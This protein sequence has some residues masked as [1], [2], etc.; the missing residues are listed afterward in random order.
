MDAVRYAVRQ[1]LAARVFTTAAV[2]TLALGI[3]GTTAIFTLI[4]AVMLKSL[5]VA[6]P[7]RLYRIGDGT[8]CCVEGGPQDEWGLFSYPLFKK[9]REAAPEFD[10]VTAFQAGSGRL[11]VRRAGTDAAAKPLIAEYVT[12][13]YFTTLGVGAFGGRMLT[14]ADDAAGAPPVVVLSHHVWQTAYGSDA[15]LVG[16]SLVIEGHPFTVIGVS[17]PGFFGETLKGNPP[18]VW[19]P[20]EQEPMIA[21]GN[22]L[23]RQTGGAWLRAIG[24]LRPGASIDG[25]APRLTGLLRNWMQHDAGY[26]ANWMPDIVRQLPKQ[27]IAVVPAGGGI[28]IMKEQY[29]S[30]LQILLAVCG[31][32]LLIACANVANLMLARAVARRTQTAVRLAIG[33]SRATLVLQALVESVVLALGGAA[34]GLL[35]AIGASRLLLTLA[36]SNAQ[37]LPISTAPSLPV[38]G[39]ATALA[40][41][42]GLIFGA[43]PAWFQTRTDPIDALRGAGRVRD[44]SSLARKTLLVIQATL[45]VVLVTGATLLSRTLNNLEIAGVRV[46]GERAGRGVNEPAAGPIRVAEAGRSVS[47]DGRPIGAD[48]RRRRR[49]PRPL[50]P[51]DEQLGR[52][53]PRPGPSAPQARR[54]DRCV[55]GSGQRHLHAELRHEDDPRARVRHVGP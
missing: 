23:L 5:P 36:F 18:D 43:A 51:A 2:L 52:R 55:V 1:L 30:S 32:V 33:A 54:A 50:Q 44:G 47:A 45:S 19:I 7:D 25:L 20:I 46:C 31:V 48:S 21:G 41:A 12:G 8:D 37:F 22:S 29:R 35:V 26:P 53:H 49:R 39:F 42:T 34:A 11:S 27:Y 9:L 3:G 13:N 15:G 24:R 17:P 38:L 40:L 4:N 14:L 16:A 6:D 10:E 28:G